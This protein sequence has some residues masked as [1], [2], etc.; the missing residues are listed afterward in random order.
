MRC[1]QWGVCLSYFLGRGVLYGSIVG[2]SYLRYPVGGCDGFGISGGGERVGW[3]YGWDI[4][5]I[6]L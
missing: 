2:I 1:V 3:F 6:A 4:I 5:P